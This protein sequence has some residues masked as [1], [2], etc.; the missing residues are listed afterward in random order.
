MLGLVARYWIAGLL[1]AVAA[2]SGYIGW[3][4]RA[5]RYNAALAVQLK[6]DHA[7]YERKAIEMDQVSNDLEIAR[8]EQSIL[9]KQLQQRAKSIVTRP[10]YRNVCLD[11]DGVRIIDE[12]ARGKSTGAR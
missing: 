3:E 7:K 12:A 9:Q 11:I 10:V 1:L 5:S 4:L 8:H 6:A 2:L